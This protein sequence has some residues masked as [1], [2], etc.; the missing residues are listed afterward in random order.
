M[1]PFYFRKPPKSLFGIYHP[2]QGIETH[3]IGVVLCYP[4][5]QEYIRSYRAFLQLAKLLSSN[6]FHVLR[7][8]FCG[9]GESEGDCNQGS[10]SQWLT[11]I[12]TAVDELKGGCE[13]SHIC[14]VGLRLGA[15]LSLIARSEITVVKGVILWDP[16][17]K[18][19]K[20]LKELKNLHQRWLEGSFPK[21]QI[22]LKDKK[23]YEIL[24]FP[25]TGSLTEELENLDI[26]KLRQKPA[27]NILLIDSTKNDNSNLLNE[28]LNS[29]ISF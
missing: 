7:F 20:Y 4:L 19:K 22:K 17:V 24:G 8:D 14:L 12:S 16:I 18:G 28:D 29:I 5:G 2:P 1:E 3:N 21:T 11:D 6:G 26:L 15:T 9:C 10:V 23:C 13:V 25:F 27:D